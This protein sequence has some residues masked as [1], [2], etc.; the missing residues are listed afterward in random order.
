MKSSLSFQRVKWRE[1]KEGKGH[2]SVTKRT[3]YLRASADELEPTR[4]SQP[5]QFDWSNPIL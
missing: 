4:D 3:G 1:K 2:M 5:F